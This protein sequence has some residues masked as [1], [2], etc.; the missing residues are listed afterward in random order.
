MVTI[1]I[2]DSPNFFI[3]ILILLLVKILFDLQKIS[4]YNFKN[5][6]Y[7]SHTSPGRNKKSHKVNKNR[8]LF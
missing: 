1:K 5:C 4:I 3:L 2:D 8:R 6:S 7:Y